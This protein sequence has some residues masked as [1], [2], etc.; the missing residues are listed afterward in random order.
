MVRIENDDL[1]FAGY[2]VAKHQKSGEQRLSEDEIMN[3]IKWIDV[4]V[5]ENWWAYYE[6]LPDDNNDAVLDFR[7]ADEYYLKL[8]IKSNLIVL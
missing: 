1:I 3:H 4:P 2:C 8:L 6:I 5:I 7:N